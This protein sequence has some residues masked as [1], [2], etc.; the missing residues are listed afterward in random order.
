M[1]HY[2]HVLKTSNFNVTLNCGIHNS[3]ET[4]QH[5]S[6]PR[7]HFTIPW[8]LRPRYMNG[9]HGVASLLIWKG[10]DVELSALS[11]DC[12]EAVRRLLVI[13]LVRTPAISGILVWG[14]AVQ[15]NLIRPLQGSVFSHQLN[16]DAAHYDLN[17]WK[18]RTC[19]LNWEQ[20]KTLT[21]N[22][23]AQ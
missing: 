19:S 14:R 6:Q 5:I 2:K 20:A 12:Q 9:Q 11:I 22:S 23:N 18:N 3:G 7:M 21:G 13:V 16:S 1:S 15:S 8:W 10:A 4:H 17:R